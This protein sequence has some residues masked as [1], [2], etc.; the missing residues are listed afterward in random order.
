M[1][2]SLIFKTGFSETLLKDANSESLP[3]NTE[4]QTVKSLKQTIETIKFHLN[5]HKAQRKRELKRRCPTAGELKKS[6]FPTPG[7]AEDESSCLK[8]R[9]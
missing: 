1:K 6:V 2:T 8:D 7:M 4:A 5:A 9:R 3:L